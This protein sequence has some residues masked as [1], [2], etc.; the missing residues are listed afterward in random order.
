[1]TPCVITLGREFGSGGRSIAK[2]VAELLDIPCYDKE[3]ITMAA[4]KS[5]LSEQAIAASEK[6]RTGSLLYNLYTI[7]NDLPLGDQVFILQSNIIKELAQKGP[8]I[9]VGR[10]ADY[11]LKNQSN[12]LRVFVHASMDYRVARAAQRTGNEGKD[13]KTLTAEINRETRRRASYYNYYT[14]NRWGDAEN[15]DL[16]ISAD[17]GVETCARIIETAYRARENE[18][19]E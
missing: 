6:Q 15:Y 18:V 10:C 8:C 3:L 14:D 13:V 4:K 5:G 19:S 11:V 17:L 7:G 9:I 2:R 12:V 1:M 16:S